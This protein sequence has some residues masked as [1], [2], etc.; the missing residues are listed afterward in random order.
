MGLL[1]GGR[2]GYKREIRGTTKVGTK[3]V[4][5]ESIVSWK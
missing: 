5:R 4:V 3:I 1:S 2:E